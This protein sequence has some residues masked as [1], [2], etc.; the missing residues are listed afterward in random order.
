MPDS[1]EL[2]RL[3]DALHCFFHANTGRGL[4]PQNLDYLGRKLLGV[5]EYWE[6]GGVAHG[7]CSP[8]TTR[9]GHR[10]LDFVGGVAGGCGQEAGVSTVYCYCRT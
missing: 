10:E 1:V 2:P 4:T 6:Q 8:L 7:N 5:G 9:L 3:S